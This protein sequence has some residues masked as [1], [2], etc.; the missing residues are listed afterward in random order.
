MRARFRGRAFY[1]PGA[2]KIGGVPTRDAAAGFVGRLQH[3]LFILFF[4]NRFAQRNCQ[5]H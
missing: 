1:F 5:H 2:K 3:R 4:Q